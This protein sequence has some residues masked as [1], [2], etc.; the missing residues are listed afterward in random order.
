MNIGGVDHL[1]YEEYPQV[2]KGFV[3]LQGC[4][5]RKPSPLR[6]VKELINDT[7]CPICLTLA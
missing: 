6:G 2:R 1:H 3:F 4:G 5:R 7:A